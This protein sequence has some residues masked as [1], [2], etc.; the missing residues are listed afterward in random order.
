MYYAKR[1]CDDC[2]QKQQAAFE[3]IKYGEPMAVPAEPAEPP[4][5]EVAEEVSFGARV[6]NFFGKLFSCK[7]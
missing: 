3:R 7:S 6:R 1:C 2:D 5:P 4:A